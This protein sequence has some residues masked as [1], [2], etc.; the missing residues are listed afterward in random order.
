MAGML[1]G[2]ALAAC[3]K[4]SDA[5]P[6]PA[7]SASSAGS[8]SSALSLGPLVGDRRTTKLDTLPVTIRPLLPTHGIYAAG[9]GSASKPWRAIVDL[10][11][12]T[13]TTSTGKTV[14]MMPFEKLD[15][16]TTR[17][18]TDIERTDFM[19]LAEHAWRE[20]M[21]VLEHPTGTYG[22]VLVAIDGENTFY[23]DGFG[24]VRP[25]AA[26]ALVARLKAIAAQ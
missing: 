1:A 14:G 25:P 4:G 13:V 3:S 7:A 8:A 18:L 11:A 12:N 20:P 2:L 10:S 15:M 16:E 17:P 19:S 22:E 6:A 21:P 5:T 26:A 23:L 9:G 24:P